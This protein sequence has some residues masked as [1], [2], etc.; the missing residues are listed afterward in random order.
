MASDAYI[1]GDSYYV[2]APGI[3]PS[4]SSCDSIMCVMF[5]KKYSGTQI[6][7]RNSMEQENRL[8]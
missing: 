5:V 4:L 2:D 1:V 7:K 8:V 6:I 3:A